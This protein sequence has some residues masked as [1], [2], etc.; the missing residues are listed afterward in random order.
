MVNLHR[1]SE[2]EG[3]I[4]SKCSCPLLFLFVLKTQWEALVQ[5]MFTSA[6]KLP[7]KGLVALAASVPG[8]SRGAGFALSLTG[9]G[10]TRAE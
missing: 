3:I 4:N 2:Q 1:Y 10:D 8:R 5:G 6:Q 9:T 7:T